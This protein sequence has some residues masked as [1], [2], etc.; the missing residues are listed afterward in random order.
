MNKMFVVLALIMDRYSCLYWFY[1]DLFIF[2]VKIYFASL[3]TF[4]VIDIFL[5]RIKHLTWSKIRKM[6]RKLKVVMFVYDSYKWILY[7]TT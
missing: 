6:E 4:F 1:S 7:F 3:C 5:T 2:E